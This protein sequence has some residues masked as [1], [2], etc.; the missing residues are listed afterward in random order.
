MSPRENIPAGTIFYVQ[1]EDIDATLR[2]ARELGGQEVTEKTEIPNIGWYGLFKD[3][4][5]NLIGIFSSSM[6]P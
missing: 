1:V 3:P 5:E 4:N 2:K 6:A